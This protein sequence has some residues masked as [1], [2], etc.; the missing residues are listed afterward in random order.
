[1]IDSLAIYK[2][3]NS[4][5]RQSGTRDARKI[6]QDL[7]IMVSY[8]D[9]FH[10]LLGLYTCQWNH[11][12]ILLNNRLDEYMEQMVLAHESGHDKRHRDLAKNNGLREFV[13]FNMKDTV[14]YEA[15]AFAAHLLLPDEEIYSL[16]HQEMDVVQIAQA[17]KSNI[18]LV[19]IKLQEMNKIG[20]DFK[21]PYNPDS[22]FFKK[23]QPSS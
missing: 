12:I 1:M 14:E 2:Q 7:G 4:I 19:L 15:N 6:A 11:R 5:V 8:T 20:F 16:A 18:N 17:M 21:L 10:D 9:H 13:L 23:I 3:A 22:R